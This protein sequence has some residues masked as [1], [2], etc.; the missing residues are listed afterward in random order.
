MDTNFLVSS[1]A[2]ARTHS[3]QTW[4]TTVLFAT[5]KRVKKS[6]SL[7]LN[8]GPIAAAATSHHI[9]YCNPAALDA[10][11]AAARLSGVSNMCTVLQREVLVH[12]LQAFRLD[13]KQ[14]KEKTLAS[15]SCPALM[16]LHQ[17]S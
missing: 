9:C 6:T 3:I 17:K 2:T 13:C 12:L 10:A 4:Q 1:S 15:S 16:L 5:F 14:A 8:P 7:D 11:L